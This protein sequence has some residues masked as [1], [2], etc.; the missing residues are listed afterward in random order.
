MLFHLGFVEII[1]VPHKC[2]LRGV[3]LANHLANTDN[4]TS[5]NQQTKHIQT[6]TNVNTK[7]ALINNNICTYANRKDTQSPFMTSNQEMELVYCI[8]TTLVPVG[9]Q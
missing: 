4:L 9:V 7:M 6:Q 5:N 2:V 8:L 1:S 3:F